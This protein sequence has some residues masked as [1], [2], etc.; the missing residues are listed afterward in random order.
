M[1]RCLQCGRQFGLIRHW[2]FCSK[3]CLETYQRNWEEKRKW[4]RWLYGGS[5]SG[6]DL[7]RSDLV[8]LVASIALVALVVSTF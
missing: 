1:K 7:R 4:V 8:V 3:K 2:Q 6:F 5:K